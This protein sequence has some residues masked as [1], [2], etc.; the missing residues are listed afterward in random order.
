MGEGFLEH[1]YIVY[2]PGWRRQRTLIKPERPGEP[3]SKGAVCG[4][5]E[6]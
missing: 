5:F 4:F 6:E 2:Q 1:L 3:D